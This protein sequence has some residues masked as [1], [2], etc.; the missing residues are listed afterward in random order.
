M[1]VSCSGLVCHR[2]PRYADTAP[3]AG[4]AG[5]GGAACHFKMYDTETPMRVGKST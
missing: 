1:Y 3:N 4:G 2:K 5:S